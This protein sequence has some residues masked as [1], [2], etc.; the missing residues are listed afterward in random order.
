[1]QPIIIWSNSRIQNG[2]TLNSK[3]VTWWSWSSIANALFSNVPIIS[4]QADI[5]GHILLQKKSHVTLPLGSCI[6]LIFHVS[7]L[8]WKLGE[9]TVASH[10]LPSLCADRD[11]LWNWKQFWITNGSS[12]DL[13]LWS[14]CLKNSKVRAL[15]N[16]LKIPLIICRNS[17]QRQCHQILNLMI[18]P[19]IPIYMVCLPLYTQQ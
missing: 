16:C 17:F 9:T 1:M 4:L 2:G 10:E 13:S 19:T 7:L 18:T 6:H 5:T 8:K 15:T 14:N 12:M 3:S 11:I